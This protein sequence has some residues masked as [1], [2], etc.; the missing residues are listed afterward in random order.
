VDV[1]ALEL[2]EGVVEARRQHRGAAGAL[3]VG[4][5]RRLVVGL[6]AVDVQVLMGNVEVARVD[7]G[8]LS[9]LKKSNNTNERI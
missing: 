8:L 7:D 4:E 5:P 1:V 9:L 3:G 6:G 2:P